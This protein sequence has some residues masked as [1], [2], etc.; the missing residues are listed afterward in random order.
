M[1][2]PTDKLGDMNLD[3]ESPLD[4]VGK[5][6]GSKWATGND[7]NSHFW[8][9][10]DIVA[11]FFI[12]NVLFWPF[13][14][15]A[16]WWFIGVNGKNDQLAA[17]LIVG[18][19]GFVA[20]AVLGGIYGWFIGARYM[21]PERIAKQSDVRLAIKWA[22]GSRWTLVVLQ[23]LYFPACVFGGCTGFVLFG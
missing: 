22:K 2:K 4:P 17:L 20:K 15:G 8:I 6:S 19:A 5:P 1:T 3:K 13:L 16:G 11:P 12:A 14:F 21:S 10:T 18:L 23:F 7:A 9:L